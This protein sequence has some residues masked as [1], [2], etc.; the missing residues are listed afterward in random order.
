MLREFEQG[1]GGRAEVYD[2]GEMGD[3]SDNH[4][5]GRVDGA[6]EAEELLKGKGL[7][8]TPV[9]VG[10]V[11][12]LG[13]AG[14][15][16]SVPQILGKLRNVDSVTVYRTLNTFVGKGLVHRIR[17]DDRSWMYALGS[18]KTQRHAEHKHPH[19]V[20]EGCGKVECLEQSNVPEDFVKSLSIPKNYRLNYSEVVLHG[21]C[22][23]C[24]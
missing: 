1:G 11:E 23:E 8:K 10:V 12:V 16:M 22:P 7:R 15:P 20:C 18:N 21:T 19:F 24:R 2:L 4:D 6:G 9:R 3:K 13:R 14:R 5:V 17:G